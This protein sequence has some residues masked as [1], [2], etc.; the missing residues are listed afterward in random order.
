MNTTQTVSHYN[1]FV[2]EEFDAPTKEDRN[3]KAKSWTKV[4]VAFPHKEGIGF[5]IQ[6]KAY[7][8]DGKLVVL[9]PESKEEDGSEA[10]A[11]RK[12]S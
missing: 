4:G 9:P 10:A 6:L 7:P 1:V 11:S 3:R 12:R 2:V 5:N 8:V